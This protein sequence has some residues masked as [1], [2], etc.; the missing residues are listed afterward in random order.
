MYHFFFSLVIYTS[1]D[2]DLFFSLY[3]SLSRLCLLCF[4]TSNYKM[5]K[6]KKN[7]TCCVSSFSISSPVIIKTL[8]FMVCL[9]LFLSSLSTQFSSLFIFSFLLLLYFYLCSLIN[10]TWMILQDNIVYN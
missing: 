7:Q 8:L 4:V 5:K 6:E 10:Y 3:G 9:E 2:A 1:S